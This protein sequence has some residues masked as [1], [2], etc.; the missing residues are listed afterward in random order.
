MYGNAST[1][2]CEFDGTTGKF[3]REIG[4]GVYGLGYA[5]RVR[6]D[7][8]DNLWVVDKGTHAV[9]RFNPAGLRHAEPGPAAR[10]AR[11]TRVVQGQRTGTRREPAGAAARRRLFPRADRHRLGQ[12]RQHLRQRRLRELARREVRQ[13]RQLGQVVGVA[14]PRRHARDRESRPVQ[15][16]AQ[17]RRRSPEQRLRGRSQQPPHPGVR[18]RRQFKRFIVLNA[19]YDKNRH[20]VLGS[21]ESATRRTRRSRGRSASPTGRPSI[22]TRRTRS[23]D[24]ST[25]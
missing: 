23:R 15:H 21:V 7:K 14:R 13:E 12:R 2:L 20:P 17:H 25:R 24:A 3:V 19:T 11:R 9:M 5:H 4:K 18:S 16:A 6:F 10:G 22:S 1:Q 8:Y